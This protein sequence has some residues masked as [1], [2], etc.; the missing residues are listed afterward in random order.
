MAAAPQLTPREELGNALRSSLP[1]LERAY[2]RGG[3]RSESDLNYALVNHLQRVLRGRGRWVI[4]ADHSL[5]GVRP[6]V[7]CYFVDCPFD[8]FLASPEDRLVGVVEIKWA[9]SPREDLAKLTRIQ[10]RQGILAWMVFGDHFSESIHRR[11]YRAQ[12]QREQEVRNW[13]GVRPDRG[14]T[15][16][17]CGELHQRPRLRQCADVIQAY[18]SHWWDR[19]DLA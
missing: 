1:A 19:D 11:N 14:Y 10:K 9:A 7:A 16:L 18:N 12:L 15:I 4:G 6:D 5:F 8:E 2:A 13:L 3:I 17:K